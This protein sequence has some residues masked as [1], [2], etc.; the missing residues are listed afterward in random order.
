MFSGIVE[1]LG[2]LERAEEC[3]YRFRASR[4][5]EDLA[6]GDSVA[7]N[8][9]CLTIVGRGPQ[10]LESDVSAET[11]R[12]TTLG[13]MKTDDPVNLERPVRL[14]ARLSGHVVQG[15][16]DAVG[17]ILAAAPDLRV[18]IPR[19]LMRYCVEKGSIAVDGVSLTIFDLDD[20]SFAV[21]VI[22]YTAEHTTLGVRSCGDY[23]NI[24]VDV[25]AKQIEKLLAAYLAQPS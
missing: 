6:I 18:R 12:K 25:M 2:T 4:V 15:H 8:G 1:E 7:V 23:V 19:H 16:V 5:L 14:D 9:A 17:E 24:E 20:D 21:A 13:N 3:R 10:W 11:L 22:P